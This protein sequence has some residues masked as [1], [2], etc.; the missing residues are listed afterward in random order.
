MMGYQ[1]KDEEESGATILG[2]LQAGVVG[3]MAIY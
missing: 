2:C 1:N 3:F